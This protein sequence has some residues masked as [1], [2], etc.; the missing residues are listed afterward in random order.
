[1][2][3]LLDDLLGWLF[4]G[5]TGANVALF[6]IALVVLGS[7]KESFDAR[8]PRQDRNGDAD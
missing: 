7:L 5:S 4:S 8:F 6:V 3:E 1:M 2:F